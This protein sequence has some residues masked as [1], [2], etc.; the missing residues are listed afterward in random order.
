MNGFTS[1]MFNSILKNEFHK[2]NIE[3][4]IQVYRTSGEAAS[5]IKDECL[6][7][8]M[9]ELFILFFLPHTFFPKI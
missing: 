3:A 2:A 4:R 1:M 6:N 5:Y 9:N 8:L 7:G